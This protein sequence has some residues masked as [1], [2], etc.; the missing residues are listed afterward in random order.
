MSSNLKTLIDSKVFGGE[1]VPMVEALRSMLE[2][3]LVL[4]LG[5]S[6]KHDFQALTAICGMFYRFANAKKTAFVAN[7]VNK[8]TDHKDDPNELT[9]TCLNDR[10][11]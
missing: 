9:D 5:R 8:A 4:D 6:P 3:P 7:W 11:P 10:I 2:N 1:Y